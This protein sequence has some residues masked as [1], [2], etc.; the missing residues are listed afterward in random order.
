MCI[1]VV[2]NSFH[3]FAFSVL[4]L[5]FG[6][7]TEELSPRFFGI[8]FPVLLSLAET[9]ARRRSL[10][11]AIAFAAAAGA[12]EDAISGLPVLTSV[13]VYISAVLFVRW[14]CCGR[15]VTAVTFPLCQAWMWLWLPDLSGSVFVRLLVAVPLGAVTSLAVDLVVRHVERRFALVD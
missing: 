2:R 4:A 13:T 14:S 9:T 11:A 8:G 3:I 12:F 10:F 7:V 1:S 6:G 5:V 15:Y